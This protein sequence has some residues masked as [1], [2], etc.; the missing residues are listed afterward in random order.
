[1]EATPPVVPPLRERLA[2]YLAAFAV[3]LA[4]GAAIGVVVWLATSARLVD[5]IGYTY[6]ALGAVLLLVGGVRGSGYPGAA[7]RAAPDGGREAPTGAV[8][9]GRV[10]PV[11]RRR[12]RL[13]APPNPAAF[14]QVVA[15]GAYIAVG[16]LMTVLLAPPR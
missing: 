8:A 7:G 15:G 14:W 10:D 1:M 6:S 16:V 4:A 9:G 11:E 5:A 12:G 2:G 13:M 3:G